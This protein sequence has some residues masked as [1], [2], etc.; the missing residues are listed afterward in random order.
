MTA[1][2]H[3]LTVSRLAALLKEMVEDNF[4][5]VWVEGEISNL[6]VADSGHCYFSLKDPQAQIRGVLFRPQARKKNASKPQPRA[7]DDSHP[8]AVLEKLM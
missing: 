3:I 2:Y 7:R 1:P 6:T 8:F 4:V 5:A